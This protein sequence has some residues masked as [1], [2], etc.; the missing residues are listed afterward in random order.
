MAGPKTLAKLGLEPGT[1]SAVSAPVWD[2]PHLISKRLMNLNEVSTNSHNKKGYYRFEPSLLL[3]AK[4]V[5]I[6]DFEEEYMTNSI[7]KV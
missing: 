1:V 2:M 4:E 5:M 3:K 7:K 6:G